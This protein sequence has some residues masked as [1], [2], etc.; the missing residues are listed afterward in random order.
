MPRILRRLSIYTVPLL[1]L[2][3]LLILMSLPDDQ[4]TLWNSLR[5]TVR[6]ATFYSVNSTGDGA[7]SNLADGVCNDGTGHCTLRAAIQE[8]NTVAGDDTITFDISLNNNPITLNTA[9]PDITGNLE[10]SGNG[11]SLLTIQRSTAAGTPEFRIFTINS[12]ATVTIIGMTISNGRVPGPTSPAGLGGGILNS[13]NLTLNLCAVSGNSSGLGGGGGIQNLNTITISNSTIS[14]NTGGGLANNLFGANTTAIIDHSTISGNTLGSGIYNNGANGTANLTINNSTISGN[15]TESVAGGGGIFNGAGSFTSRATVILNNS[16][17][18]GNSATVGAGGGIYSAAVFGNALTTLKITNSTITGNSS[19]GDGGGILHFS[20]GSGSTAV[21]TLTNSTIVGNT[22]G[23]G[24]GGG[25]STS[26]TPNSITTFSLRNS[27]V[28]SNPVVIGTPAADLSGE[29]DSEDYNLLRNIS[30]ATITGTTTHNITGL[31]PI[32]GPL[33]NYGGLTDTRVPLP[34]SPVIDKGDVANLPAD[35]TDV[36]GDGNTAEVLPIDQRGFPRV[37]NT[38]FDIGAVETNYLMTATAGSGQ[39]T[40]INTAFATPLTVTVTESGFTRSGISVTFTKPSTLTPSGN[41][42]QA[43][44]VSTDANG[45]AAIGFTANEKAGSYNVVASFSN[46]VTPL[47]PA[48]FS[49][50][51]LKGATTTT[52]TSS[53]NPSEFGEIVSLT[54]SVSGGPGPGIPS[55]TVQFKVDG[56]NFGPPSPLDFLGRVTLTVS[57]L[58][59]GSHVISAD[60]SGDANY[61]PSTGTSPLPQVVNLEL[62]INDVTL[63]EGDS[64]TRTANFTVT[65]T[66]GSNVQVKVDFATADGTAS[67]GSDYQSTSGTLTFNPGETSQPISVVINSDVSFESVETFV[68][69]LSSPVNAIITDAQG[70]GTIFNDDAQGGFISFSQSNYGF[71]ESGGSLVITVNRT[72]DISR[73]ATV[74]YST[75]DPGVPTGA[76]CS[77]VNGNASSRCDFTTAAGTLRFAAGESEKTFTVLISQDNYVEGPEL[78]TL[79]LSNPTGGALFATPSI[80]T[81]A[82]TDDA[83]EPA[84]NPV[85]DADVFVRQHYHDFLNREADFFGLQFWK[86]QITECQQPGATCNAE[87]RRIN[88]SAAFFLSIEFQETGYLVYRFYKSAFGDIPGTPVPLRLNEFLPDTQQIGKDV[89]IGQPGAEQLL[90]NNKVAFALDFVSRARFT[91]TYPTALTPAQFVDLLFINASVTPS[92][93]DRNAAINEFGGAGHTADTAARARAL[94]QVAENSTLKQQETN[95]A[96]V[97]MQYFGYLRRNPNDAPEAG[98]NFDGYNFWLAKLNQFN[99]NFVNAELVKAF[100]ISG[101]YRQR[102]GP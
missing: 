5:P 71:G 70:M 62:A 78:L 83:T 43:P 91:T 99:G 18:S 6:A 20:N 95:K 36:D 19:A 80:A 100:I 46:A 75:S 25:I 98:L 40:A 73:A 89:V 74:D 37:V 52:V 97:L 53:P 76:P 63:T 4:G 67:A 72:N 7:D 24:H 86:N 9:L 77:T 60:Y 22:A 39:S 87:V 26:T 3:S 92:T 41:F 32:L 65:L 45:V 13:G 28:A 94:R 10:F 82:I 44:I 55:G 11:L 50:T 88:V 34:N 33:A 59:V 48:V 54:A 61:L 102:F 84:A 57:P 29:F 21:A 93:A 58:A 51:N 101:E 1:V 8:A 90:E 66:A 23:S 2:S 47:A 12:G 14:G 17:V 31:D 38:K 42:S 35:E 79:T 69:N 15:S 68:V 16:T 56:V 30:E 81:M 96:F 49:L 27:I 85:D 64:G